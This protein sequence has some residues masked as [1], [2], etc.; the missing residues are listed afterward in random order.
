MSS[1]VITSHGSTAE[2]M[3]QITAVRGMVPRDRPSHCIRCGAFLQGGNTLHRPTCPIGQLTGQWHSTMAKRSLNI[4][5]RLVATA[6]KLRLEIALMPDDLRWEY[7]MHMLM[8]YGAELQLR[9]EGGTYVAYAKAKT[10]PIRKRR[11]QR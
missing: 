3:D 8:D 11:K 4:N 5:S 1:I 7:I 10:M 9:L 2:F 6:E